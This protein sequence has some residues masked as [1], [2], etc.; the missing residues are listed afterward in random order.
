MPTLLYF[1]LAALLVAA[2]QLIKWW[3]RSV[4]ASA[5]SMVVIEGVL[6]LT[7]VENRGAAFG[8][9]QGQRWPLIVVTGLVLSGAAWLLTS[10]RLRCMAER[11]CVTFILSGGT[12][13]FIDRLARGFV[14]DY[15]DINDLFS[16]PMFNLADCC[17]V[18]GA[19][20]MLVWTVWSESKRSSGRPKE[21]P[22]GAHS[23]DS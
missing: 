15:I 8:I 3:A 11:L 19:L 22:D 4:L 20:L 23:D 12:G 16:Y 5:G 2:D 7:Y 14:V 21:A 10:G 17:V 18:V 9:F 1:C 6:R 13:N